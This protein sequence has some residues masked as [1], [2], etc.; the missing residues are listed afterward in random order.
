MFPK[1]I[2]NPYDIFGKWLD[3]AKATDLPEPTAMVLST[4]TKNSIPSSRNVLLKGF[5]DRGF[6][7]YTN[8]NSEK[9]RD[10]EENPHASLCFY[11]QTTD[12]Q[13]RINGY[14]EKVSTEESDEYFASRARQSKIGAWASKQSTELKGGTKELLAEVAKEA[15]KF[16]LGEVPRPDFWG[17]FR[18]IPNMIEFWS[19]GEFRIHKRMKFTSDDSGEWST[20]MLYP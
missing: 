7:F 9:A 4:C 20:Q 1:K 10:L 11:W 18:V 17:G 16:G 3:E 12:R 19:K 8:Y 13:V 2:D 15:A 5:D 6:V 14:V